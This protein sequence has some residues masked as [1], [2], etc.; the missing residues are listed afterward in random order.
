MIMTNNRLT[1]YESQKLRQSDFSRKPGFV[2]AETVAVHEVLHA[3]SF[4][5]LRAVSG[6]RYNV[7]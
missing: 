5:L 1:A 6:Y 2:K 4:A 7:K 3:L